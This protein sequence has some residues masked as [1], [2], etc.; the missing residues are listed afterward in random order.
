MIVKLPARGQLPLPKSIL[1]KV[2]LR[3]R[4]RLDVRIEGQQIVL[5]PNKKKVSSG[6]PN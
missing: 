6:K 4:D 3:A 5:I 1:N 2:N